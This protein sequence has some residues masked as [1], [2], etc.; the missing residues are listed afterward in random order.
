MEKAQ[1]VVKHDSKALDHPTNHRDVLMGGAKTKL[2]KMRR[3]T[4]MT[5]NS[6]P[7][8]WERDCR[9][10][11]KFVWA[12]KLFLIDDVTLFNPAEDQWAVM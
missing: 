1:V 7:R 5:R 4:I 10:P 9:Q 2:G 12:L 11:S 8:A 6:N 3:L